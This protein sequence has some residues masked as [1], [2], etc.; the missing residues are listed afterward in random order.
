MARLWQRYRWAPFYGLALL[1]AACAQS[2]VATPTPVNI[3]IA[4]AT[5]MQPVLY[6]LTTEY[7]RRHPNVRFDLRGG[8]STVGEERVRSGQ[9]E[10][11]ASTLTAGIAVTASVTVDGTPLVRIPIGLDGLAI[12]V[13]PSNPITSLA[14]LQLRRIY[15]GRLLDW[16]ELGSPA[17]EILLVSREDGSGS[18]LLFERHVMADEA[19][20][21]T[22]VVMPSS[23]DV[24]AYVARNPQ[25]IGYVS[26]AYVVPWSS[27]DDLGVTA[28][29]TERVRVLPLDGNLPTVEH[30][31]DQSYGLR[32]P[33]F[34]VSRGEPQ[35]QV[36]SFVDFVLSP[37]GQT[38]VERYH[39]RIR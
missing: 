33:L 14:S 12:V 29:P 23:A 31:Q 38:I 36:R 11:G 18:R 30:L 2:A 35:G 19:V 5:A 32:Q 34:L 39:A 10:L 25:A 4:G 20:S 3:T 6:D 21:L 7:S 26:R 1:L 24:V 37:A 27:G 13:H 15:S 28:S 22:A 8:G 16:S 9:V 17:G